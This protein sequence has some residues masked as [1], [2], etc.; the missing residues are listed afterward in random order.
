[1]LKKLKNLWKRLSTKTKEVID[2]MSYQFPEVVHAIL[3]FQEGHN[4]MDYEER[5][6]HVRSPSELQGKIQSMQL[7]GQRFA[8]FKMINGQMVP[9]QAQSQA[10]Q[11]MKAWAHFLNQR[12]RG[13]A[14]PQPMQQP[15]QQQPQQQL[16]QIQQMDAGGFLPPNQIVDPMTGAN[17]GGGYQQTVSL[18]IDPNTGLPIPS[19]GDKKILSEVVVDGK[20]VRVWS[21]G[22]VEA[23]EWVD[24]T[25]DE[26]A[27]TLKIEPMKD[28]SGKVKKNKYK[29]SQKKWTK[30]NA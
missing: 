20:K 23:E 30:K 28:E 15:Q 25:E 11:Y 17:I 4:T 2:P 1:M 21:D 10:H 5:E 9:P 18:S 27:T 22:T 19:T 3:L 16:H 26:I 6:V 12:R 14:N 8:G 29:V 24:L 7:L 13:V